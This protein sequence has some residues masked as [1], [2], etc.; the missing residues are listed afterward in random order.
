MKSCEVK[1]IYEDTKHMDCTQRKKIKGLSKDRTDICLGPMAALSTLQKFVHSEELCISSNGI[2]EGLI[3][4]YIFKDKIPLANVLDFSLNNYISNLH[5]DKTYAIQLWTIAEKLYKSVKPLIKS[6]S[7]SLYKI[8]KTA[9][10]L[11]NCGINV[12]YYGRFKHSFYIISNSRI[13]GLSHREQLISSYIAASQG[14][15]GLKIQNNHYGNI[16][17]EEDIEIIQNLSILLRISR[18]LHK[19]INENIDNLQCTLLEN[20]V[21]INITVSSKISFQLEETFDFEKIFHRKLVVE[22]Q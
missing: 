20:E 12:S 3:Y 19:V 7:E 18:N 5:M 10:L 1:E 22:T 11:Y 15:N 17:N 9:S 14:K 4:E 8:L 21:L 6:S 13:N 2:R 16:I